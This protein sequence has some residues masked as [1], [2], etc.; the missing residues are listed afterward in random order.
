MTAA[1]TQEDGEEAR[2]Q[3]ENNLHRY[4]ERAIRGLPLFSDKPEQGQLAQG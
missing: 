3:K 4:A 2:R 1:A